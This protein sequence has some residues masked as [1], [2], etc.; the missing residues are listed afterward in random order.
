M[1]PWE[2]QLSTAIHFGRGML[3]KLGQLSAPLGRR[4]V[5]VGY[6]N[7][8]GLQQAYQR[9]AEAL[10]KAG[11]ETATFYEVEPEPE[12]GAVDA[13]AELVRRSGAELVIGLGGGSVLDVAKAAAVVARAG[14]PVAGYLTS[15]PA[16]A[17]R[18]GLPVVAVP[19]TAGTG[20]EVSDIAVFS[21]R[22][23]PAGTLRKVALF[24]PS[25]R[26]RLAVVDPDLA[27][28]SPADLTAACGADA[29]GHAIEACVSR[30]ANPMAALLA[31]QAVALIESSLARATAEPQDPEPREALAWAATLAGAAFTSSGVAGAHAVAQALGEVLRMRHGPAVALATPALLRH[32]APA[33]TEQYAELARWCRLPDGPTEEMAGR[34][35]ERIEELLRSLNLLERPR[36]DHLPDLVDRLV[37]AALCARVPLVQNPVRLDEAALRAVF[38][39]VLC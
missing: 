9:G 29:L 17:P 30:R 14:A 16:P 18:E 5:I 3:R 26:P 23:E 11:L 19:T 39:Q 4:A 37:A 24:G 21:R 10:A 22:E 34:F 33:C 20:S 13:C 36:A 32:N 25:L 15:D 2:F 38:S 8:E 31:G 6:R 1:R 7:R 35:V 12:I 27:V 28:G